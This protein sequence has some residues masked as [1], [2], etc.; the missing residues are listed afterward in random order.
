[1]PIPSLLP[2]IALLV[3]LLGAGTVLLVSQAGAPAHAAETLRLKADAG[4]KL[5]FDKT[6]LTAKAGSVTLVMTNPK[7]SG[8]PHA[9][10]VE[11]NGVDKD[12]KRAAPGKTSTVTANLKA[13]KYVFYCPV[14]KH[15][16]KGMKGKLTVR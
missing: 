6:T 16:D 4:G 8:I 5:K 13:G 15:K 1:M 7:S 11:G 2:R 12:G 3:A 10:A 9:I 14:D